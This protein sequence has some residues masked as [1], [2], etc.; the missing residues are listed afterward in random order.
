[1]RS[2][3]LLLLLSPAAIG[4]TTTVSGSGPSD[5][6]PT[7]TTSAVIVV[8]RMVNETDGFRAEANA[9]FVRVAWP[10]SSHDALQ[11]IG[12][13]LDL[14]AV[15]ACGSIARAAGAVPDQRAPFVELVD[16]GPVSLEVGGGLT[17]LVPRQLPDVTDVVSGVVY[18]R[19]TDPAS[20]P[21]S[22]RYFVHIGRP[23]P[24]AFDVQAVAPADPGNVRIAGDDGHGTI[25][26]MSRPI[27][28]AWAADGSEGTSTAAPSRG[29]SQADLVYVDIHPAGVR[30]VLGDAA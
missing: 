15:G 16:V 17:R 13:A 5:A 1:M 7:L 18:A 4:C 29:Q 14:P 3:A 2:S 30:C 22:T 11:A 23:G 21:A 26:A 19:A 9:R 12:A 20:L 6:E 8:E 10:Y 27:E 25:V 28:F 24:E